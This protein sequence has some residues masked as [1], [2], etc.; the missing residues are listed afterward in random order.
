MLLTCLH[1]NASRGTYKPASAH[2]PTRVRAQTKM[3]TLTTLS[4]SGHN[5]GQNSARPFDAKLPCGAAGTEQVGPPACRQAA[6]DV[7]SQHL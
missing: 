2:A 5:N 3:I 6:S 4:I 7:P 1:G